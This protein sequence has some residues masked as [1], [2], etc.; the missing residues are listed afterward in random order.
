MRRESKVPFYFGVGFTFAP[1]P[2]L[3]PTNVLA[4]QQKL[5][6]PRRGIVF[7]AA[8]HQSNLVALQRVTPPLAVQ[9]M[10]VAPSTTGVAQL[11]AISAPPQAR[12]EDFLGDVE[13][14]IEAFAEVWPAPL[15]VIRRDCTLRYLYDTDGPH[16]FR[17]LWEQRLKQPE[18]SIRAL[19][20]PILGGGLRFVMPPRTEVPD[21]AMMEVKIESLLQNPRQLFVET[22]A[23]WGSP[24]SVG[25]RLD[26]RSLLDTVA[27]FAEGPVTEFILARE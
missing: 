5:A 14:I 11:S 10:V 3:S 18:G 2:E 22:Q 8:Q 25:T 24:L 19:G 15:Q 9:L 26:P 17:Y 21:D 23:I 20:R 1:I 4:F 27:E 7:Q 13:S 6:D 16:A 12:I